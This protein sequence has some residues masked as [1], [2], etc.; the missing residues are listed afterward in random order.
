MRNG[1]AG[2]MGL[3]V[4]VAHWLAQTLDHRPQEIPP[5]P[6][7]PLLTPTSPLFPSWDPHPGCPSHSLLATPLPHRSEHPTGQEPMALPDICTLAGER[8]NSK[9]HSDLGY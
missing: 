6:T 5:C 8:E 1:A 9:G 2:S 7:P 4:T 3:V